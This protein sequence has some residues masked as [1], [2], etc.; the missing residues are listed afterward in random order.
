MKV[1]DVGDTLRGLPRFRLGV[2]LLWSRLFFWVALASVVSNLA[3][4]VYDAMLWTSLFG[5][6]PARP[7][8]GRPGIFFFLRALFSVLMTQ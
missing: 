7:R 5:P 3:M 6:S 2:L 1:K 4:G 8:P